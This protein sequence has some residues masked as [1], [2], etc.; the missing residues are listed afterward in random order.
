MKALDIFI[1]DHL[2]KSDVKVTKTQMIL[3]KVVSQHDQIAQNDLA[4]LTYRDKASLTRLI[5]TMEKKGLITRSISPQD[6][7]V[8]LVEITQLGNQVIRKAIPVLR[9]VIK[10]VEKGLDPKEIEI[11]KKVLR[12]IS[13]NIN[14]DELTAPMKHL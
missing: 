12:I 11:T 5:D 4:F 13:N 9:N 6:K 7:R 10:E 1:G 3:L 8:K 2:E 14:A